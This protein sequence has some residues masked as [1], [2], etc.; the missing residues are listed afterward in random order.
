MGLSAVAT[1]NCRRLKTASSRVLLS[2][3]SS[4]EEGNNGFLY[5]NTIGSKLFSERRGCCHLFVAIDGRGTVGS[6]SIDP[7]ASTDFARKLVKTIVQGQEL[8]LS[9]ASGPDG[10]SCSLGV[11]PMDHRAN[12]NTVANQCYIS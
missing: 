11:T 10:V 3:T 12:T 5:V 2:G 7:P 9:E 1:R 4:L 8:T 6:S